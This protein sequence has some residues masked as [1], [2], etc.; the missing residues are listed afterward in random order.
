MFDIFLYQYMIIIINFNVGFG[1]DGIMSDV[2]QYRNV[3][4]L[5][6]R[7]GEGETK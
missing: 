4:E 3:I 6:Y 7:L 5:E 1:D 2:L